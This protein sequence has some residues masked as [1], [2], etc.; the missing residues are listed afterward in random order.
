MSGKISVNSNLIGRSA[1]I[2]EKIAASSCVAVYEKGQGGLKFIH[3]DTGKYKGR[4]LILVVMDSNLTNEEARNMLSF[5][6]NLDEF[7][8]LNCRVIGVATVSNISLR[9]WMTNKLRGLKFPII[10]DKGGD[11]CHSLG[12]LSPDTHHA[13][14]SLA[15]IDPDGC[16]IHV[17]KYNHST[18]PKHDTV[19]DFLKIIQKNEK[20]SGKLFLEPNSDYTATIEASISSSQ[21]SDSSKASKSSSKDSSAT[22]KAA[23]GFPGSTKASWKGSDRRSSSKSRSSDG[24]RKPVVLTSDSATS[25]KKSSASSKKSS[26]KSKV[27]SA[28][29]DLKSKIRSEESK[30]KSDI[31]DIKSRVE[32]DARG[33]KIKSDIS[34]IKAKLESDASRAESHLSHIYPSKSRKSSSKAAVPVTPVRSSISSSPSTS[35]G[36]RRAAVK[37]RASDSVSSSPSTS[38]AGSKQAY[39]GNL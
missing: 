14:R 19:I 1:P 2:N 18:L 9:A 11:L 8:A 7:R 28:K 3:L 27:S 38:P 36:S 29:S 6:D 22:S 32:S 25:Y 23:A 34:D 4:Y 10:A 24:R 39:K 17:S 12:V 33:S 21:L 16:L 30:I 31:S 26:V 15:I 35:P 13:P 37:S 5:N 20:E